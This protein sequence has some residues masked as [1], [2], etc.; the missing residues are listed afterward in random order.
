MALRTILMCRAKG[1]TVRICIFANF[2]IIYSSFF[3]PRPLPAIHLLAKSIIFH[4]TLHN[5]SP[6]LFYLLQFKFS[7]KS[8]C[9]RC[10][11]ASHSCF[12][13]SST[14]IHVQSS[15]ILCSFCLCWLCS[16]LHAIVIVA[17]KRTTYMH[18]LAYE[19]KM[20]NEW[21]LNE[22]EYEFGLNGK[23]EHWG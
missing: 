19:I 15:E 6:P 2:H 12:L 5:R 13:L 9:S 18:S 8:L 7:F 21:W 1:E 10:A 11:N 23:R 17:P 3:L 20:R 14:A 22:V 16:Q 4:F